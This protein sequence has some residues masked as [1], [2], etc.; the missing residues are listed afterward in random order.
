SSDHRTEVARPILVYRTS[1]DYSV[2]DQTRLERVGNDSGL[3]D[4]EE[5]IVSPSRRNV[6]VQGL[7]QPGERLFRFLLEDNGL[8]QA[9][10]QRVVEAC[11]GQWRIHVSALT[12]LAKYIQNNNKQ[13]K[14]QR[15]LERPSAFMTNFLSDL[16]G[17]DASDNSLKSCRGALAVPLSFIGYMQEEVYNKLVAQLM[18]LVFMKTRHKGREI[19]QWDLNVLLEQIIKEEVELLRSN[20]SIE[21][22]M[23]ISL[24]L[25]LIFTVTRL[26]EQFSATL[27]NQTENEITLE[28]VKLKK[29]SRIIVL[30][31][32][33]ALDQRIY[34]VRWWKAWYYNRDND[35]NPTTGH[36]QNTSKLNRINSPDSLSKGIR[37]LMQKAGIARGFT[38]TSVR[39]ATIT[40]LINTQYSIK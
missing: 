3:Q 16:M 4:E 32:K 30:K 40:K 18:K 26:A 28:A 13:L 19:E 22:T 25:C 5:T 36:L 6:H 12:V 23:T 21:E 8:K 20:L 17:K 29:L 14:E 24:T 33:E 27:I 31:I 11:H 9:V 15:T 35:L 39:S 7:I 1:R 2:V 10:V 34:P 38:V 37:S